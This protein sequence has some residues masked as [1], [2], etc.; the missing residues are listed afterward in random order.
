[1]THCL[2]RCHTI[3][4]TSAATLT[5]KGRT[6][7]AANNER[8]GITHDGLVAEIDSQLTAE[9]ITAGRRWYPTTRDF[10]AQVAEKTGLTLP[11]VTAITAIM[12]P[13]MKWP[14][15]K[16]QTER[17]ASTFRTVDHIACPVEAA[18]ALR[19]AMTGNLAAAIA[20]AR[21]ADPATTVTGV[22]RRSFRDNM[23]AP[24]ATDAVTVDTHMQRAAMRSA[25]KPM[26]LKD[27]LAYLNASRAATNGA[28]AGY[29]AIADAVRAVAKR[30][31]LMPDE[32]Q[33]AYWIAVSGSED[34]VSGAVKASA[35]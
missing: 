29:V 12:S 7:V 16:L 17:I 14:E 32:V 3:G 25:N 30:R 4:M 23:L 27:S 34:G 8:F 31:G 13:R 35:K 6:A 21:G 18:K 2:P 24:A 5:D 28:G 15:N 11:Q 26:T 22:K 33:A 19:G 1:M 9:S 20:V 10:N